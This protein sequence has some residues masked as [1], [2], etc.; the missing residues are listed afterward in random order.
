MIGN[1]AQG[2]LRQIGTSG[3]LPPRRLTNALKQIDFVIAVHTLHDRRNPLQAHAGIHG[4]LGQR[5]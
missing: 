3:Q 4:R 1:H 2:T 5:R